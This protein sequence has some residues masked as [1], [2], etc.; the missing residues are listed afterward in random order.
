MHDTLS[1]L[2]QS[3]FFSILMDET[4]DVSVTQHCGVMLRFCGVML[5]FFDQTEGKVR[6]PFYALEQ[7]E[8]AIADGVFEC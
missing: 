4:T 2:K 6:F 5:R 8:S 1:R 7:V 3:K